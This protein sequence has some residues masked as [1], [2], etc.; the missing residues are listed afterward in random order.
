MGGKSDAMQGA[1]DKVWEEEEG[2]RRRE[3]LGRYHQR[4]WPLIQHGSRVDW[5][6]TWKS[7]AADVANMLHSVSPT[8]V[9]GN[10][11]K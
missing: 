10:T 6:L 7:G 3:T 11:L 1:R 4:E 2:Q 8:C 9:D 5:L